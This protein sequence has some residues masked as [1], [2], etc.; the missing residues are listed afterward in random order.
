MT[1][2]KVLGT[3]GVR[4]SALAVPA[5][6]ALVMSTMVN[7]SAQITNSSAGAGEIHG[8]VAFHSVIQPDGS[9]ATGVPRLNAPCVATGW[10]FSGA[11]TGAVVMNVNMSQY[12]GPIGISVSGGSSAA[13]FDHEI[14]TLS[15]LSAGGSS[16]FL[17]TTST[18]SCTGIPNDGIYVRVGS[19]VAVVVTASCQVNAWAAGNTTFVTSG[20]FLPCNG[21]NPTGS[22]TTSTGG[23]GINT[24]ITAASFNGVFTI[25]PE[26]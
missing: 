9:S 11:S 10:N 8:S 12:I 26:N 4:W 5:A 2:L 13:C 6:T 25:I 15:S 20:E 3:R 16:Q 14:G 22:C 23:D 18:L 7:A 17:S 19:H 1:V 24:N 21:T